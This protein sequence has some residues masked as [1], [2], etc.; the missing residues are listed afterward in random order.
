MTRRATIWMAVAALFTVVNLAGA[1]Y[2]GYLKEQAHALIHVVLTFGGAYIMWRIAAGARESSVATA[3]LPAEAR[4][5][6]LQQSIDAVALETER[7]G[8]AQRFEAKLRAEKSPAKSPE[9]S[10]DDR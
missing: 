5:D 10:K 3:G 4:L 6:Q 8:E 2:A 1:I 9:K 7:I